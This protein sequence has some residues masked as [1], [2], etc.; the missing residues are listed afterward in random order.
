MS[1]PRIYQISR[2][3]PAQNLQRTYN[4]QDFLFRYKIPT[5][6]LGSCS[7]FYVDMYATCHWQIKRRSPHFNVRLRWKSVYPR[8]E[9]QGDARS[10]VHIFLC[11]SRA[12]HKKSHY[13]PI[14]YGRDAAVRRLILVFNW[15]RDPQL[16]GN[17][18]YELQDWDT[19]INICNMYC[20]CTHKLLSIGGH[21]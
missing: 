18:N 15:R 3:L 8:A 5:S 1:D 12:R 13:K 14:R 19:Y 6:N 9:G 16:H 17:L 11:S 2:H 10:N 4:Q 21:P 20:I 7:A